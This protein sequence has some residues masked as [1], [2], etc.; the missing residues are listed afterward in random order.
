[1]EALAFANSLNAGLREEGVQGSPCVHGTP[2]WEDG[3]ALTWNGQAAGEQ[4]RR[5]WKVSV[6]VDDFL[7]VWVVRHMPL[8]FGRGLD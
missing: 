3:A 5:S 4:L 6:G 8:E 7:C 1:V 2:S